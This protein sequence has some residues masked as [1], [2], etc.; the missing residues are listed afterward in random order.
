MTNHKL[1]T[2]MEETA[3]DG[4]SE[5]LAICVRY[6]SEG[7]VKERFLVLSEIMSFDSHSI[8]NKLQQQIQNNGLADLKCVAQT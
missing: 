3:R 8:A 4:Q 2:I 6:V 5:Q 1:Y 7:A